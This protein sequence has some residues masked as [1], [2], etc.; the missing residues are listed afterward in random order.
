MIIS[1]VL[2]TVSPNKSNKQVLSSFRQFHPDAEISIIVDGNSDFEEYA[3]KFNTNIIKDNNR[4]DPRGGLTF[5]TFDKYLQR[6]N[7]HCLVSKSE[8]V[9]ILED[10]VMTYKSISKFPNTSCAGPRINPYSE[11]LNCFLQNKF[12]TQENYGYGMSGGSIF[13]REDFLK[14]FHNRPNFQTYSLMD[15]RIPYYSDVGLTLLFQIAGF[16][17][18]EWMD[19]SEKFHGDPNQ[20][21]IRD[22]AIDHNDKRLYI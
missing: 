21:I 19:V 9:V 15:Y 20:R 4:C 7:A 17:Y 1:A 6:I 2:Q 22:S 3:E 14:S 12:N 13:K 8:Y 16:S 18:S 5:D 10:D 11:R